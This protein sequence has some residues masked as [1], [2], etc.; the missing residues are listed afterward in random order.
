MSTAPI[1]ASLPTLANLSMPMP[2]RWQMPVVVTPMLPDCETKLSVPF[3]GW[4]LT[5][6]T[7]CRPTSL[8][9]MPM[10]LGPMSVTP[11]SVAMRAISRSASAP[12]SPVSLKPAAMAMAARI[13][14]RPHSL[15]HGRHLL[16]AHRQQGH[17]GRLRQLLDARCTTAVRRRLRPWD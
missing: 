7:A 12:D 9:I 6:P 4:S 8:E 1:W 16:P 11:P 5:K 15:Q 10:Q 14:L 3:G 13:R 17:V 2:R